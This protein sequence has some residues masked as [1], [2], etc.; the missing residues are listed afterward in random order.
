MKLNWSNLPLVLPILIVFFPKRIG[1]L[2]SVV[3]NKCPQ[4]WSSAMFVYKL[5][6]IDGLWLRA[7]SDWNPEYL[8][9]KWAFE[10][11]SVFPEIAVIGKSKEFSRTN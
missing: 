5:P 6:D 7:F 9:H 10:Q 1:D 2:V 3:H 8:D 11:N 4:D